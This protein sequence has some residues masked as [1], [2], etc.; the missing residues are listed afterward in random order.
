MPDPV[1]QILAYLLLVTGLARYLAMEEQAK[2][3]MP[4]VELM[5]LNMFDILVNIL[6]P[7]FVLSAVSIFAFEIYYTFFGNFAK[8]HREKLERSSSD[9]DRSQHHNK[10]LD[11]SSHM[12]NA[13]TDRF[14]QSDRSKLSIVPGSDGHIHI[15]APDPKELDA[16]SRIRKSLFGSLMVVKSRVTTKMSLSFEQSDAAALAITPYRGLPRAQELSVAAPTTTTMPSAEMPSGTMPPSGVGEAWPMPSS[17]AP[18]EGATRTPRASR[19]PPANVPTIEEIE[20]HDEG[21]H[22]TATSPVRSGAG[23]GMDGVP[24]ARASSLPGVPQD[25]RNKFEQTGADA[26]LFGTTVEEFSPPQQ[27]AARGPRVSRHEA[28]PPATEPTIGRSD[29]AHSSRESVATEDAEDAEHHFEVLTDPESCATP[30]QDAHDVASSNGSVDTNEVGVLTD[31]SC[32]SSVHESPRAEPTPQ[33][34]Q[35]FHDQDHV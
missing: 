16:R 5:S 23:P 13:L 17:P 24:I 9:G 29:S 1:V 26:A 32:G 18:V 2:N 30:R 31:E 4:Y 14:M 35:R 21:T 15:Q 34:F 20:D 10:V 25:N 7:V 28:R 12:V 22:S 27:G 11:V 6:W 19:P 33:R 8:K 3:G